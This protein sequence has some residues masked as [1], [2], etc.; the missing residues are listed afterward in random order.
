MQGA[1]VLRNEAYFSYVAMTKDEAQRRRWTFYEAVKGKMLKIAV[2][3]GAASGK[4]IVCECFG[5]L[6]AH[7]IS[8]DALAR[9][10]VRPESPVLDAIADHFG[11]GVLASDGGLDRRK[12]R[13]IITRDPKAR[14]TLEGL[15]HPEIFRLFEKEVAAIESRHRD[16][17][18][19]AEVPLLI[20]LGIQDQF[21]LVV[22]VEAGSDLQKERLMSRDDSSAGEAQALLDIQMPAEQK[23][24]DADY[25]I[26]N[27]GAVKEVE[28]AAGEIY[29]KITKVP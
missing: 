14:K 10:A 18:V 25:I 8:M 5:R 15:I 26:E 6:G 12:L 23:R 22:L 29:R 27:R 13:D 4:S 24:S 7:V 3:G 17:V 19:V 21:D 1:R 20:E 11:R 9:G 2:T 28:V 16:A